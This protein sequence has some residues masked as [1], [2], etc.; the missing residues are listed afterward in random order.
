MKK[1]L[2][3]L[4]NAITSIAKILGPRLE[5]RERNKTIN[6]INDARKA[7][8][9]GDEGNLNKIIEETRQKRIANE[10]TGSASVLLLAVLLVVAFL[11]AGCIT[12]TVVVPADR[13]VARMEM[14]DISGWFVPDATMADL[15]ENYVRVKQLEKQHEETVE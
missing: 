3:A 4:F 7:V 12:K 14:N 2:T 6:T 5:Q 11:C 1:L 10:K 15:M 9:S 8:A 13:Y